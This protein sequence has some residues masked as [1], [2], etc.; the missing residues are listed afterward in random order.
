MAELN[1][2]RNEPKHEIPLITALGK[3]LAKEFLRLEARKHKSLVYLS[4]KNDLSAN[5]HCP[6]LDS[7]T[8]YD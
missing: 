1:T 6:L 8:K 4:H 3:Y 7:R 2:L 5:A